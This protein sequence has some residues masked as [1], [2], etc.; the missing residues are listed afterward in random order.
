MYIYFNV[1]TEPPLGDSRDSLVRYTL[2][3]KGQ[4]QMDKFIYPYYFKV[5]SM[6]TSLFEVYIKD[7]HRK[8]ASFLTEQPPVHFT[9]EEGNKYD[10]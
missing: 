2:V 7:R 5:K 3:Q 9:L 6:N 10:T 8:D 4:Y 1:C